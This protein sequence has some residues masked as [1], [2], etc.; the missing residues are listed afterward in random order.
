MMSDKPIT[1]ADVRAHVERRIRKYRKD[2]DQH[3]FNLELR[4]HVR[5]LDKE[6][7][8]ILSILDRVRQGGAK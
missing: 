2:L 5:G 1:L 6:L 4:E 8:E 3:P 7:T